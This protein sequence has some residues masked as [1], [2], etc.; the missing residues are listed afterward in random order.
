MIVR[1]DPDMWH[2]RQ[3][4]RHSFGSNM[5]VAIANV[6]FAVPRCP[7]AGEK[8]PIGHVLAAIEN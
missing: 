3:Q 2:R 5:V 8:L 4:S 6:N 1:R 7:S